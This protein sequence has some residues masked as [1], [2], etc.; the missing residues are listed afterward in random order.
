MGQYGR[1]GYVNSIADL[2]DFRRFHAPSG[3]ILQNFSITEVYIKRARQCL[4][5]LMRSHWMTD[6]D[7][8]SLELRR[9]WA[10]LAELQTVIPFHLQCYKTILE[11]CRKKSF[12]TST[13]LTFATRFVAVF[14][15]VRV[16]GCRPMTYQHLTVRMFESA[17]TNAG[18]KIRIQFSLL[19]RDQLG[20]CQ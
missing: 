10:T 5:K 7:I 16:K 11:E 18:T 20:N 2:L 4:A 12:V 14:M 8:A 1:L 17:K 9:S 13:N 6:L 3:P 15:F 19:R